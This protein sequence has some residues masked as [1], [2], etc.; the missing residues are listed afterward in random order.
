VDVHLVD[1]EPHLQPGMTGELAF[2][3][4]SR[5]RAIVIPSQALQNVIVY[6]VNGSRLHERKV[7]LGLKS[8]ERIEITS[9]LQPG[10]RIALSPVTSYGDNHRI[11]PQ[12]LD[13]ITA[14]GL[15]KPAKV[16]QAFKAFGH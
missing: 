6:V 7:E 11:R 5:E 13:P 10:D 8:V 3:I 9:G 14:A 4:A 15:N 1:P 2:V 12:F 16:E